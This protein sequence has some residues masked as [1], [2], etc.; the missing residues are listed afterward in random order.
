MLLIEE[1]SLLL[2]NRV[3]YIA[4]SM[5]EKILA[6]ARRDDS[7]HPHGED[8]GR[9]PHKELDPVAVVKEILRADPDNGPHLQFLVRMYVKNEFK[10]EDIERINHEISMFK[11]F[12]HQLT[13][14]DLNSLK[15]LQELYTMME[16]FQDKQPE[17]SKK[18]L[19]RQI[20]ERGVEV[21]IDEPDFKIVQLLTYEGSC[22][23]GHGTKWCTWGD[24]YAHAKN[25][26]EHY[27]KQGPIF[28]I[29]AKGRKFQYH[30][31]SGQIRDEK[32]AD[33]QNNRKD[34]EF[35]SNFPG[36]P[37]AKFLNMEIKKHYFPEEKLDD[38]H[39]EK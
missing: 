7:Y 5:K 14:K 8:G 13:V 34:I 29:I 4:N 30:F 31:H 35:L 21:I 37:W 32:D 1:L 12:K 23:Y 6:A 15:S 19:A 20:K 9:I 11:R 24:T 3:E 36:D 39:S 33:I 17:I 18:E 16:P 28:V 22:A 10:M 2:E 25:T 38:Y 26:F 27:L